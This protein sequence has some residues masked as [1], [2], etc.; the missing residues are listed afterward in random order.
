MRRSAAQNEVIVFDFPQLVNLL[1]DFCLISTKK[2]AVYRLNAE[3]RGFKRRRGARLFASGACG[4]PERAVRASNCALPPEIFL[5]TALRRE[6][7][8]KKNKPRRICPAGRKE[9][10]FL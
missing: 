4:K 9:R 8:K 7:A 3:V 10:G 6:Y 5:T 1:R 2:S